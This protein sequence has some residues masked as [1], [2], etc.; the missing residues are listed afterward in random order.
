MEHQYELKLEWAGNLGSGTSAYTAY[1]RDHIISCEDKP[2]LFCSSDPAFRG[3]KTKYNPEHLLLASLSACHMLWYLHFC[4][5]NHIIVSKYTD[6][7]KGI[8]SID[9]NSIGK[10]TEV[11]LFPTVWI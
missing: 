10:F 3:D 5:D 4:A 1:S 8:L 11:Q 7:P 2:D 9:K 6:Q